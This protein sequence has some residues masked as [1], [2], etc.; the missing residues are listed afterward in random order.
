MKAASVGLLVLLSC[1]T[2]VNGRDRDVTYIK[3]E[4]FTTYDGCGTL[5]FVVSNSV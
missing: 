5:Y 4:K 3:A 1:C 2:E